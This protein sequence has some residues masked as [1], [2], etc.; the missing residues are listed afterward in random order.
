M[1]KYE[2]NNEMNR[3][4]FTA[5]ILVY[6]LIVVPI[7]SCESYTSYSSDEPG[8]AALEVL[9]KTDDQPSD[10]VGVWTDLKMVS[11]SKLLLSSDIDSGQVTTLLIE[12][13]NQ[14]TARTSWVNR[15][16]G[17]DENQPGRSDGSDPAPVTTATAWS[18]EGKGWWKIGD[19]RARRSG[20]KLL[21]VGADS[22]CRIFV[23]ANDVAAVR[24]DRLRAR[25]V[26]TGIVSF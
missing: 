7:T 6:C 5:K 18:Y 1:T 23:N 16:A 21:V 14:V 8:Y 19:F 10:I 4:K 24:A 22:S 17:K 12:P 15:Y 3:F 25:G 13:G 26:T 11:R 9:V 2:L 20:D